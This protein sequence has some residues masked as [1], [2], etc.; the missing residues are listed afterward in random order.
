MS[1]ETTDRPENPAP[2]ARKRPPKWAV[3]AFLG[4]LAL[5]LVVNHFVEYSGTPVAWIDNDLGRAFATAKEQEKRVFL[6]IYD[7]GSTAHTRNEIEVFA[8]LWARGALAR[9][10]CCRVDVVQHRGVGLRYGDA[11]TPLMLVLAPDGKELS[12]VAGEVVEEL[13]FRT[14]VTAFIV[15]PDA[16]KP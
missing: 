9:G 1:A 12:R 6:Y 4:L 8:K 3:P 2:V 10:V 16:K 11:G 5:L 14:Y 13:Q 7:P 15:N